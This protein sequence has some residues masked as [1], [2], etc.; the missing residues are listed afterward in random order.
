[1][2][3][4]MALLFC[5]VFAVAVVAFLIFLAD[6]GL[7]LRQTKQTGERLSVDDSKGATPKPPKESMLL[8]WGYMLVGLSWI[9][10]A[11]LFVL[12]RR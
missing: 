12:H 1:M 6:N 3:L 5:I 2:N 9:I 4:L 11:V 8:W 10:M 7:T